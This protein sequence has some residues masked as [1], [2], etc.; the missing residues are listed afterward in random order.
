MSD[1]SFLR[2]ISFFVV[3]NNVAKG[4]MFLYLKKSSFVEG[5]NYFLLYCNERCNFSHTHIELNKNRKFAS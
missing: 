2:Q 1:F 4:E 5:N 3:I